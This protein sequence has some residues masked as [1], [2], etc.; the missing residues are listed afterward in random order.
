MKVSAV[1]IGL[2]HQTLT[3]HIP[4]ILARSDIRIVGACDPDPAAHEKFKSA[5]PGIGNA[6]SV[7]SDFRTLLDKT[8]PQI[9]IV[10]VPH[11]GYYDIVTELCKRRVYFL[12]EKPLARNLTEAKELLELPGFKEY[13]FVAT[14]RRYSSLYQE[15]KYVLASLETPYL[16]SAVY[17]LNVDAPHSGWRGQKARA[18]GGCLID[19]GYHIIDQ[20][21]WWFGMP[22]KINAQ[23]STLAIPSGDYDAEDSATVSFRYANGMH[24]TLLISR[25]AGAK[26]E[27][28]EVYT[29]TGY[30]EGSKER[31]AIHDK[32]GHLLELRDIDS[33]EMT[34][35]QLAFF[36][37][38]V[39]A[40]KGFS[41]VQAQHLANMH[42]I[43]RCYQDAVDET[44]TLR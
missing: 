11:D 20:L 40:L 30:I 22:E 9:A 33:G 18:G 13:G 31:L 24:G 4:A 44:A 38:R 5:F 36:M 14:Q 27:K 34:N 25:A 17:K 43:E 2:G 23:I 28:Y 16:F 10:A 32:K 41:D 29:P 42:F 3:E 39:H 1:I 15:A 12:K 8:R 21:L 35:A 37:S 19:M 7:Y 6:I 26:L